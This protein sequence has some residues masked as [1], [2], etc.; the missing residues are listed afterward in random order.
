M[1]PAVKLCL[2]LVS[3]TGC[4]LYMTGRYRIRLEFAPALYM[5]LGSSLMF[6]AGILNVMPQMVWALFAGGFGLLAVSRK[7]GYRFSKRDVILYGGF[8]GLLVWFWWLMRGAHFTSYDNFSHWATIVKCMLRTDR[9][10]GFAD[11]V[12]RFQSYPPGSSLY[13]YYVCRILGTAES[14][15][16]WAQAGMLSAFLFCLAAFVSKKNWY[17]ICF[18]VL[19]GIWALSANNTI[20]ELRVDTLLPLAGVAAVAIIYYYRK[21]PDKAQGCAGV[22]FVLLVNIKN[23]GVFFFGAGVVFLLV[24]AGPYIRRH[25]LYFVNTCLLPPLAAVFLWKRHVALV[26]PEGMSSKHA[27]SIENYGQQIAK[28]TTED[29]LQIGLEI[30][31]RFVSPEH[32][33]VWMMLLVTLLLLTLL[34][35]GQPV[36]GVIR[37]AAASWSWLAVYTV[38]LYGMYLFSMPSGEALLLASYDRY[39]LS[40]LIFIYGMIVIYM[41]QALDSHRD[42]G[43][44]L[45]DG[46]KKKSVREKA[47]FLAAVILMLCPVAYGGARA[48]TLVRQPSFETTKR[49]GLQKLIRE[50]GIREGDSCFIYCGGPDYDRRYLFY[51]TR[52]ELWTAD[53]LSVMESSFEEQ[54]QL[55]KDYDYL[56]IW[57]ND[58]HMRQYLKEQGLEQYLETERAAVPV[59]KK[60]NKG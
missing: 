37:L 10:P 26:F 46:T 21:K 15:F 18:P 51:L 59:R 31:G 27:M 36:S 45:A 53:V 54:K 48:R 13:I 58:T 30:L 19:Y 17:G 57:D 50:A 9:L 22:L 20:Y 25:K 32:V 1:M 56:I 49:A 23:S 28:K 29:I 44:S 39:I 7:R 34:L 33:E 42:S 40:V 38:S 4:L 12:I 14:C 43:K 55:I 11:T 52:Y 24:Y 35:A 16:L 2:L 3:M 60:I 6:A 41:L 8:L 5:A 47:A